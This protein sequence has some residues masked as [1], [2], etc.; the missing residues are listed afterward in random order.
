MERPAGPDPTSFGWYS[1]S[2]LTLV[3][4]PKN[5]A[6]K[7]QISFNSTVTTRGSAARTGDS[8]G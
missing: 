5:L 6:T 3:S 1:L 7:S 2:D 4:K 8:S